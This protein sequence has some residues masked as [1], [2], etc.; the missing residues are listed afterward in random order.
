MPK[1]ATCPGPLGGARR[2][3]VPGARV[4]RPPQG[5]ITNSKQTVQGSSNR[6][7]RYSLHTPRTFTRNATILKFYFVNIV[8]NFF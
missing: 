1:M 5:P 6:S 8:I 3:K 7:I 4:L 2:G